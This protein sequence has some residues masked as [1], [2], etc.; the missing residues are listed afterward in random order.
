MVLLLADAGFDSYGSLLTARNELIEKRPELVQRF[1]DASIEGWYSYLY[2]DP[3]PAN[4][5]IRKE[6][7][8]MTEDLLAYGH[9]VLRQRGI[10]DSGDATTLGI[11]AMT[12]ARWKSF[13]ESVVAQKLYP[14]ALDWHG[15]YTTRFVNKGIGLA[16]RPR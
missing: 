5:L 13:F 3:A 12:D 6:N 10:I 8:E 15:A 16:M 9:G 2:Q 4:A 14:A 11:G 1:I 7:P